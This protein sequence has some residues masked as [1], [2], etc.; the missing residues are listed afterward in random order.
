MTEFYEGT[1]DT[2]MDYLC[3]SK[4]GFDPKHCVPAAE[5]QIQQLQDILA[6]YRCT[7]RA[8]YL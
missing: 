8:A 7:I 3:N 6:E 1:L 4:S 2:L 5:D